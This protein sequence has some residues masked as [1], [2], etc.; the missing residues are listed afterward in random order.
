LFPIGA[1][2]RSLK[3]NKNETKQKQNKKKRKLASFSLGKQNEAK[4]KQNFFRFDAKKVFFH[5]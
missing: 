3:Q 1:K 2:H 5:I 4:G